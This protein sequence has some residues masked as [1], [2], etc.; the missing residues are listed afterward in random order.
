MHSKQNFKSALFLY[1]A[2]IIYCG[3]NQE[4]KDRGIS[5]AASRVV[6]NAVIQTGARPSAPSIPEK[7]NYPQPDP[8]NPIIQTKPSQSPL[9]ATTKEQ[10]SDQSPEQAKIERNYEAE[11]RS[12]IGNPVECLEPR[13]S[14]QAPDAITVSLEAHI[15]VNGVISRSSASSP[16]LTNIEL[17]CIKKRID[18]ARFSAPVE[19]APRTVTAT[20]VLHQ[21]KPNPK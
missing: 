18:V 21:T 4:E 19:D 1:I 9:P 11:L 3:C 2:S 20:I 5:T 17:S 12:L 13:T 14:D 8:T 15:T 10:G 16:L 6:D 7:S